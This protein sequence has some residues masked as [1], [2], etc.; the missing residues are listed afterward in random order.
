MADT[1][2]SSPALDEPLP[3]NYT[4][5]A[6]A[7]ATDSALFTIGISFIN[8]T[9]VLPAFVNRLSGSEFVVGLAGGLIGAAWLLPQLAVASAVARLPRKMPL[10]RRTA[11][12]GRLIFLLTG[13]MIALFAEGSPTTA[14]VAVIASMV[15]FYLLDAVISVPW[16]D[17]VGKTIPA[18]RRGRVLGLSQFFGGLGSVGVGIL[19]RFVLG[20]E[21]PWRYPVNYALLFGLAGVTLLGAAAALS[22]IREP[23]TV[24]SDVKLPALREVISLLPN[25][26][27]NDR[28]FLRLIIVRVVGGFVIM[29]NAFYVL[30]ATRN[31]GLGIE[32]TGWFVSAQVAGSLTS[33]LLLSFIQDRF[34]PLAHMRIMTSISLL[35]PFIALVLGFMGAS[36]GAGVLYPYL[37]LYF[38]LGLHISSFGWP[39]FNWILEYTEEAK[40]PLY[41][42]MVNTLGAATMLAPMLGGWIVTQFSYPTVFA[43]AMIFAGAS[44]VLSLPLPNPRKRAGR[45]E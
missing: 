31:L 1:H 20:E 45:V 34:G 29:G 30:N 44:L 15:L 4:W 9:T 28:P 16:F 42:G 14:L 12:I 38:F 7:I 35:P 41:I 2:R 43:L 5:N 3:P 32:T 36:L 27:L 40:R 21:S 33:G 39:Y 8:A 26:L 17:L 19:V 25:I 11:W 37:L 13:L 10:V 22:C 18:R 6:R 24:T 23:E